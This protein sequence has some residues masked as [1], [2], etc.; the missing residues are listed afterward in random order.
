LSSERALSVLRYL[1]GKAGLSD[2]NFVAT[3]YADTM[4]KASNDTAE[5]RAKNRRVEIIILR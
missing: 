5:N 4:P 1:T 3:G 2:K